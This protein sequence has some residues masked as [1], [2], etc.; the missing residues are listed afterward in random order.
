MNMERK[1]KK[2]TLFNG[3]LVTKVM[4]KKM[5]L[6]VIIRLAINFTLIHRF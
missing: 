4:A 1:S 2:E 6:L 3:F 5:D